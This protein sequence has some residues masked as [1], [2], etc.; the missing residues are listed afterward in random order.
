MNHTSSE[1]DWAI[2]AEKGDPEY[3]NYYWIFPDRH[4]PNEFERTA[5]KANGSHGQFIQL[6]D[7]RWIWST[8]ENHQWDLN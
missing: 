1:H 8:F 4:V 7:G 2:K 5:T 3:S 6:Q